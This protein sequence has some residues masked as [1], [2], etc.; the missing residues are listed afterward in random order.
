LRRK[1]KVKKECTGLFRNIFL[2][3]AL[4][5]FGYFGI[6]IASALRNL[7]G[8]REECPMM[9]TCVGREDPSKARSLGVIEPIS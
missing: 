9:C 5:S 2:P 6:I 1:T 7:E 4:I 8:L 3:P